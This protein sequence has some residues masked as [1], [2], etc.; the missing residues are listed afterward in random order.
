MD[1]FEQ[2]FEYLHLDVDSLK[3]FEFENKLYLK[4]LSIYCL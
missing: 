2:Q 4:S 3:L 1:S